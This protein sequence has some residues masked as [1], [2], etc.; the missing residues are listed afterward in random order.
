MADLPDGVDVGFPACDLGMLTVF[1]EESTYVDPL[2][3]DVLALL[4]SLPM[5]DTLSADELMELLL[6]SE[7]FASEWPAQA[8][9]LTLVDIINSKATNFVCFMILTPHYNISR[10]GYICQIVICF[11]LNIF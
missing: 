4:F 6:C 5:A 9:R 7:V 8:V 3:L 2:L 10:V 11:D 1:P